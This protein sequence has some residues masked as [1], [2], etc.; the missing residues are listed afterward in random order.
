MLKSV[1]QDSMVDRYLGD[2][3]KGM[4]RLGR[5]LF[6]FYWHGEEFEERYGKQDIPELEVPEA[7]LAHYSKR[8]IDFEYAYPFGI[9]EIS[10]LAYR[11]DFDLTKHISGAGVDMSYTDTET[12]NKFVP[13]VIEPTFGLDRHVLAVL[14]AG[15]EEQEVKPGD[16][17]VV[18]HLKPELAPIK[19][20]VSPLLRNKPELVAKAREVFGLLKKEFGDVAWDDNG[21][22]G[23]RYR[24]QDEIGTP[25]CVVIDF[26]TLEG[27]GGSKDTVTIRHRDTMEQTRVNIADL[28]EAV[29]EQLGSF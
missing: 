28:T 22:I 16:V 5:I 21:N 13:H 1:R 12:G 11:T 7:G 9:K 10:G 6:T 3:M 8:T 19:I 15:Y 2:L 26:D 4:D 23:K 24:R 18:L 17:R 27:E 14:A 20:A 29:R 25:L